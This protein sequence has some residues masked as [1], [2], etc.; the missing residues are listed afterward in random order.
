MINEGIIS[1]NLPKSPES[2]AYRILRTNIQF[3]GIDT[4]KKILLVTSSGPGE[5]KTITTANIAVAFSQYGSKVL[6]IDGDLR[7]SRIHKLFDRSNRRGLT[8]A[9]MEPDK[10]HDYI[11]ATDIQNLSLLTSG[12]LPPNPSEL[13]GSNKMKII[14]GML[15]EEYDFI[16]IDSPPVGMVTDAQILSTLADGTLLVAAAEQVT[17]DAFKSAVVLLQNVN[18]NII[19]VVLNKL[20]RQSHGY[21]YYYR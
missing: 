3:I 19:G 10:I 5:G 2:E 20:D 9:L 8:N 21:Y 12:P 17:V 16:F 14:L 11:V 1:H 7:K 4:S 6:V 18:A 13:L 15:E